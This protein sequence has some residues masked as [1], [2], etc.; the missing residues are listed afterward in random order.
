VDRLEEYLHAACSRWPYLAKY[1]TTCNAITIEESKQIC[2]T[3]LEDWADGMFECKNTHGD[4][5]QWLGPAETGRSG[6]VRGFNCEKKASNGPLR[7]RSSTLSRSQT[8]RKR[9]KGLMNPQTIR[10]RARHFIVP[11]FQRENAIINWRTPANAK[12]ALNMTVS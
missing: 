2:L 3:T 10:I 4:I 11:R 5:G 9:K 6:G 8:R 7:Q 12:G 1:P